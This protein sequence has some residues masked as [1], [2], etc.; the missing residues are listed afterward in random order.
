MRAAIFWVAVCAVFGVACAWLYYPVLDLP[1]DIDDRAALLDN[2]QVEGDLG[3]ILTGVYHP[4]GRPI[5]HLVRWML[6][7][8][9]GNDLSAYHALS[10]F[11]H[12]VNGLIAVLLARALGWPRRVALVSG[13]LFVISVAPFKAVYHVA[14]LEY[15]LAAGFSGLGLVHLL[16]GLRTD[17]LWRFALFTLLM[18]ASV[19]SHVAS[20]ALIPVYGLVAWVRWHDVRRWVT[21]MGPL[22]VLAG[23]MVVTVLVAAAGND[24]STTTGRSASRMLEEGILSTGYV[25]IRMYTWFV[26]QLFTHGFAMPMAPYTVIWWQSLIGGTLAVLGVSF[27]VHRI[28]SPEAI[29]ILCSLAALAPFS[30]QAE[31]TISAVPG[32]SRYLYLATM[33]FCPLVASLLARLATR[34]SV[35]AVVSTGALVVNS[36]IAQQEAISLSQFTAGRA[37]SVRGQLEDSVRLLSCSMVAGRGVL[38]MNQ[39]YSLLLSSKA[40]LDPAQALVTAD[41]LLLLDSEN[42]L[43]SYV[44]RHLVS[45]SVHANEDTSLAGDPHRLGRLTAPFLIALARHQTGRGEYESALRNASL[46]LAQDPQLLKARY[47]RGGLLLTFRDLRGLDDYVAGGQFELAGGRPPS[48]V[49]AR[50]KPVVEALR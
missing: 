15:L 45:A 38:P 42:D 44:S 25:T 16:G 6:Y 47:L 18:L 33:G 34:S 5:G 39:V 7:Q 41:S 40:E 29:L 20:V 27:A 21:H 22:V 50:F 36:G 17:K 9:S 13:L 10:V 24:I 37:A 35:S 1:F 31:A 49:A 14:S 8:F 4:T 3:V 28:R 46:A 11:L 23:G 32:P 48:M 2:E 19:A 12:A 43:L 30:L 26:S